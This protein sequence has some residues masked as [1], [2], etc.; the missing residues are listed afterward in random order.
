MAG[1]DYRP[2]RFFSRMT[3]AQVQRAASRVFDIVDFRSIPLGDHGLSY[4]ALLLR[5]PE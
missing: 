5:R 3:D 1:D 4:Q 2:Q